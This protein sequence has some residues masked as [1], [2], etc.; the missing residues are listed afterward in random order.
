VEDLAAQIRDREQRIQ[1]LADVMALTSGAEGQKPTLDPK[2][3]LSS[4]SGNAD[5][6][7]VPGCSLSNIVLILSFV[8]GGGHL[9]VQS[10]EFLTRAQKRAEQMQE[11]A[12]ITQAA[13]R[14]QVLDLQSNLEAA[15]SREATAQEEHK[16]LQA[17][18]EVGAL[19]RVHACKWI[20]ANEEP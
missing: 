16:Q 8:I 11:A 10:M 4:L 7:R 1:E 19:V 3:D 2:F 18:N 15:A 6:M 13:L 9:T 12:A 20:C 14:Q 17:R 5:G